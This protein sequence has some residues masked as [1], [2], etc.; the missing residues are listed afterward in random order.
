MTHRADC[1]YPGI[2]EGV[3]VEPMP[4]D[5]HR[6]FYCAFC[7]GKVWFPREPGGE[8]VAAAEFSAESGTWGWVQTK[9]KI[10]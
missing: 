4:A 6:E 3:S 5:T 1:P 9:D 2:P 8:L 10:G 7:G